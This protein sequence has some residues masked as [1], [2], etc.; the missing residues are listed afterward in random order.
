MSRQGTQGQS[1]V[2]WESQGHPTALLRPWPP[3]LDNA[4]PG[5][6]AQIAESVKMTQHCLNLTERQQRTRLRS[7]A[8]EKRKHYSDIYE[9]NLKIKGALL[10][11]SSEADESKIHPYPHPHKKKK[12][13]PNIH[14][15]VFIALRRL[16]V[17]VLAEL[18]QNKGSQG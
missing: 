2:S 12:K 5:W 14:S 6:P 9:F 13:S 10:P 7:R 11:L 3:G 4:V 17:T 1:P 18:G 8:K 16:G 15:M